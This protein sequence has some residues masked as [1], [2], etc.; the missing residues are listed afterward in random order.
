[1]IW[2]IPVYWA[3][4]LVPFGWRQIEIV[5]PQQADR[6]DVVTA[7]AQTCP[8]MVGKVI[9]QDRSGPVE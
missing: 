2:G 6:G 4:F 7:L 9:R 3:G 1:M 8:Q 5:E